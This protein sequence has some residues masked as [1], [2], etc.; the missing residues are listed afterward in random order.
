[1]LTLELDAQTELKFSKLLDLN[2]SNYSKLINSMFDY[3][4][5][6][7]QK[8]IRN[9]EFDFI[10][11]ERKYKVNSSDFYIKYEKGEF[12]EDSHNNDYMIWSGEYESY[13][14]FQ[15]ELKKLL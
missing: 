14:E 5:N 6:E 1:M 7:L 9:L 13:L 11:Y 4:I 3:R 2:N 8:G 15:N 10:N 12:G